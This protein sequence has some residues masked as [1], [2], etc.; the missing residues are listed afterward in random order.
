MSEVPADSLSA[1]T[2]RCPTCGAVQEWSDTCRRCRCDLSLLRAAAEA[3]AVCRRRCL[4]ALRRQCPE[5]ALQHA[6][7][8]YALD[9]GPSSARL[10]AVCLLL[11]DQ[12]DSAIA[13]ANNG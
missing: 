1:E 13:V 6:R 2:L 10:L 11:H 3:A 7:R 8:L 9:A 12:W 5:A 4:A